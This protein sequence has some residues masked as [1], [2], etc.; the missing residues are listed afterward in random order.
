MIPGSRVPKLLHYG[1]PPPRLVVHCK[2]LRGVWI[3]FNATNL[4]N[5]M[6]FLSEDP[7]LRGLREL[8]TRCPLKH[9]DA[10]RL[11]FLNE[12]DRD[13]T[14]TAEGSMNIFPSIFA[15]AST[16]GTG[17]GMLE[18]RVHKLWEMRIGSVVTLEGVSDR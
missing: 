1:I 14:T 13:I 7:D 11:R 2:R 9:F 16:G 17:W 10:R 12:T 3:H 15:I 8:P 6:R 18:S 5:D 4:V